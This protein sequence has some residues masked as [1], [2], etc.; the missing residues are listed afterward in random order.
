M[1]HDRLAIEEVVAWRLSRRLSLLD[2]VCEHLNQ[3]TAQFPR[4]NAVSASATAPVASDSA[5]D[6]VSE[7]HLTPPEL[8]RD[9]AAFAVNALGSK[10]ASIDFGDPA[11]G[12]GTFY[13]AL[14]QVVR[15]HQVHSALG[16]DVNPKQ[17]LAS[18]SRWAHRG[19]VVRKGDYLHL[20]QLPPRNL[21]LANPPYLRHQ[22]IPP[23]YK[24]ALRER[25]SIR[26][27]FP[28]NAR[29][30]AYVYFMLLSHDWMVADAVA[31]W[32]VP[33]EFMQTDYGEA[34]RWYLTHRVTVIRLHQFDKA[35]P[36]FENAKVLPAVVV[37]KNRPPTAEDV[38]EL[39]S[40]GPM[41][42]PRRR[43]STSVGHLRR[44][45]R[46]TI[47]M[48]RHRPSSVDDIHIDDLFTVKRGIATGANEFFVMTRKK[49]LSIGIPKGAM[50]PILPKVKTLEADVVARDADGYPSLSPQLVVLDAELS[51]DVIAKKH[52][53]LLEYL[54]KAKAKGFL[55]RNLV[56]SRRP[57]YR[58]E[59]REP[60]PFLCT[61]M[62]RGSRGSPPLRFILNHSDAIATNTYLMLYPKPALA[63][64]LKAHPELEGRLFKLLQQ[65]A[66][67][68]MVEEWRVHAG[69]LHKIEPGDLR[70]VR[71]PSTP[72][73]L[74][75][76]VERDL[77]LVS[78]AESPDA[79]T[80]IDPLLAVPRG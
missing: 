4:V 80:K 38:V 8:A 56:R 53:R 72:N 15:R 25:A 75:S 66:R 14:L 44:E 37:F 7:V 69:G 50:R 22:K 55:K 9:I 6:T 16:F 39:T 47:P 59:R 21:I 29:A 13:S 52:P 62:G 54:R 23:Q 68:T 46:W 60:A 45:D 30:G 32:L 31:A 36:Q 41:A 63:A 5:E 34:L 73:W 35:S 49:A 43:Q 20:E 67:E 11:V 33:A 2:V 26:S 71:I 42:S 70:E 3:A 57:W 27:G 24:Q 78:A 12:T 79:E 28:I 51:E 58:Q 40:G 10:S 77:P 48:R 65:S 61:Y 19:L 64:V 18:A 17:V 74:R 1:T 76:A